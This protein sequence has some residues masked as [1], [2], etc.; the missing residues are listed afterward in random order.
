VLGPICG[1]GE[2]QLEFETC[3]DGNNDDFDGCSAACKREIKPTE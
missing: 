2:I 1:D 3:D